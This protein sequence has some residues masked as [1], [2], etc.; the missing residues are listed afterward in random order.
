MDDSLFSR[1]Y[2]PSSNR[3]IEEL[4]K[5][6]EDMNFSAPPSLQDIIEFPS[7]LR[8][9][10]MVNEILE[11][12]IGSIFTYEMYL[13]INIALRTITNEIKNNFM[14]QIQATISLNNVKS[15]TS[16]IT[17]NTHIQTQLTTLQATNARLDKENSELKDTIYTLQENVSK[18]SKELKEKSQTS[19]LPVEFQLQ[20]EIENLNIKL[21][22][23]K[24]R[25]MELERLLDENNVVINSKNISIMSLRKTLE[26]KRES[27]T[28]MAS[29]KDELMVKLKAAEI[30][31]SINAGI[32]EAELKYKQEI[33]KSK[34]IRSLEVKLSQS[35]DEIHNLKQ[36]IEELHFEISSLQ[37][38]NNNFSKDNN[39][40]QKQNKTLQ[41]KLSALTEEVTKC[42]SEHKGSFGESFSIE[43]ITSNRINKTTQTSPYHPEDVSR[44][45]TYVYGMARFISQ[46]INGHKIEFK[47]LSNAIPVEE[48]PEVI[49]DIETCIRMAEALGIKNGADTTVDIF[50]DDIGGNAMTHVLST[51]ALDSLKIIREYKKKVF[52][53]SKLLKVENSIDAIIAKCNELQKIADES[54]E[55]LHV[56]ELPKNVVDIPNN[57][58]EP[59]NS[60]D[61]VKKESP[62]VK[63]DV[64]EEEEQ[65]ESSSSIIGIESKQELSNELFTL[66]VNL[67]K[68]E[69][70][71][72]HAE[73]ILSETENKLKQALIE[74]EALKSER[75]SQESTIA[76]LRDNM[77]EIQDLVEQKKKATESRISELQN[78]IE[79]YYQREKDRAV[80]KEKN[81][82]REVEE[83]LAKEKQHSYAIEKRYDEL[84]EH[85]LSLADATSNQI[86]ELKL[87]LS[88]SEVN[89]AKMERLIEKHNL[90]IQDLGKY[91]ERLITDGQT[92]N[93]K[94]NDKSVTAAVKQ[95]IDK[96]ISHRKR[97]SH[98]NY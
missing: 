46:I 81:R 52:D 23:E 73:L 88:E 19:N 41:A 59:Q 92:L 86:N 8:L 63:I 26:R 95:V 11:S 69:N 22:L 56:N 15:A 20:A 29:K 27:V 79:G 42:E 98:V 44:L 66:R 5:Y 2:Q 40:L 84:N 57:K 85:V 61:F 83:A 75:H 54:S 72:K 38:Q 18:L 77:K 9:A 64:K 55:A 94:W 39:K 82:L 74:N 71:K 65:N 32:Q 25:A 16:E 12:A 4:Q 93:I 13:E 28:D 17:R 45:S 33:A 14:D 53:Y 21:S 70:A 62:E 10:T 68:A 60:Y 24:Q 97:A 3:T 90:L 35:T 58:N 91:L 43:S 6:M 34:A 30:A 36:T 89:R 80:A 49:D 78:T 76:E 1:Q 37:T 48:D 51:I 7:L 50:T 31:N 96:E 47:L 67:K 87:K